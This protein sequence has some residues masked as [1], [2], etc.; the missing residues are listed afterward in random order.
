MLDSGASISAIYEKVFADIKRNVPVGQEI[1]VMPVTGV[2]IST[3]MQDRSRKI[4]T[5]TLIPF[6]VSDGVTEHVSDGIFLVVSHLATS[7][8]LGD[9]WLT[10]NRV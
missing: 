7:I 2:T 3:A 9:D 6:N 10:R 5:E 8:I 1:S 4:T